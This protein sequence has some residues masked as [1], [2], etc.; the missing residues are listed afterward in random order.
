MTNPTTHAD[1]DYKTGPLKAVVDEE[2]V[3][4]SAITT[5]LLANLGLLLA[6]F[7]LIGTEQWAGISKLLASPLAGIVLLVIG[8]LVRRVVASPRTL[9]LLQRE[10]ELAK[11]AATTAASV[12]APIVVQLNGQTVAA[13]ALAAEATATPLNGLPVVDPPTG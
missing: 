10:L 11:E 4:A 8:W 2:P 3:M 13:V 7:H 6:H 1:L 5:W 9:R 12:P